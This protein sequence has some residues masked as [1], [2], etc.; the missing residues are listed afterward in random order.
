MGTPIA[1]PTH[2]GGH[3]PAMLVH[4]VRSEVWMCDAV[5]AVVARCMAQEQE[6]AGREPPGEE[7]LVGG[8][9]PGT[10]GLGDGFSLFS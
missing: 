6:G 2:Q 1:T 9:E 5:C 7:G 10:V 4:R 8:G 3:L